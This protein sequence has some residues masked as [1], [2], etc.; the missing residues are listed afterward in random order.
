LD[1][2][3]HRNT[4]TTK[5]IILSDAVNTFLTRDSPEKLAGECCK[6]YN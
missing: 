4:K 1:V 5:Q 3:L 2:Y 6:S